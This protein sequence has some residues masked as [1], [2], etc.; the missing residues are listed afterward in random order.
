[1]TVT[2]WHNPR[3][4]K[5]RGVL[6]LLAERGVTPAIVRYLETSPSRE[7]LV[8]ALRVLGTEDPRAITRVNE[9]LYQELSLA[10]ASPEALLTALAENPTLIERPIVFVADKAVVAR[11]PELVLDLL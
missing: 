6:E 8:E 5:S 2:V 9:P 7:E 10:E 11:P 4:S 3:C 1:M